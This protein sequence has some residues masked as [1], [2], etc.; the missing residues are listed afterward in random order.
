MSEL[1][2]AQ[3]LRYTAQYNAVM[4]RIMRDVALGRRA[5]REDTRRMESLTGR[6]AALGAG[7]AHVIPWVHVGD[8]ASTPAPAGWAS[9]TA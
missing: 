9:V 1:D 7:D 2:Q 8:G 6:M 4:E 5:A 3:M